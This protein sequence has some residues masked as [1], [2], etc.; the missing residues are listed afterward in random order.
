MTHPD[1]PGGAGEFRVVSWR[2]N[3]DFSIDV[4]GRT[5]TDTMYDLVAGPKPADVVPT[6]VPEEI[7]YDTGFPASSPARRSSPT[8]GPR[9]RR[10]GGAPG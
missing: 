1:M 2:L 10:Y 7:L 6:P 5:T 4:Q 3:K 8:T 9:A